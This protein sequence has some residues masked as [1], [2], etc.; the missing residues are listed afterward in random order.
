MKQQPTR[1]RL[2]KS[3]KTIWLYYTSLGE[4]FYRTVKKI[5]T[6]IGID[7]K[8]VRRA[9]NKFKGMGVLSWIHGG[10]FSH[11]ANEYWVRAKRLIIQKHKTTR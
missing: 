5:A 8:T 6:D 1:I 2:T 3:E 11:K 9:N 4:R 7:E 10:G